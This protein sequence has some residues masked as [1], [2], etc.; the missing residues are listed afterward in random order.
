MELHGGNIYKVKREF[1]KE[2]L[3]YSSNINPL[4]VPKKFKEIL[5]E[6]LDML[7]RYPDVEYRDLKEAIAKYNGCEIE[8][9]IVGNGATEVL[10]LY[11]KKIEAEKILIV[12]PTFAEYERAAKSAGKIVEYFPYEKDFSLDFEKLK[13]ASSNFQV[14]VICN[15]NNPTG[16]FQYKEKILDFALFL[17]KSGKN[18]FIDEAFIE[19]LENWKEKSVR[20]LNLKNIFILRALTKYF[21]LPGVRL[22]YGISFNKELL[23]EMERVREP[24]SVNAVAELAGRVILEDIDYIKATDSWIKEE[25]V[26]LYNELK[27]ID[28]IVPEKTE[29]NFILIKLLTMSSKEFRERMLKENILVRDASNFRFLDTTYIRVAVKDREK[30]LKLLKAIEKVVK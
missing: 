3:D 5:I 28:K 26:W 4:G 1:G 2:V 19:F 25:K 20:N 17:E 24:W 9:I 27:K 12:G 11:M 10:F 22:G 23:N 30:N 21:A 15:P 16:K 13:K 29:T 8:N 6:N 7:E 14:V 18:L